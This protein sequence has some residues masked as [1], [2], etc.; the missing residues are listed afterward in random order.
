M[1]NR[2]PAQAATAARTFDER[3][4]GETGH[5]QRIAPVADILSMKITQKININD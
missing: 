4:C 1:R 2:P 3:R 5:R